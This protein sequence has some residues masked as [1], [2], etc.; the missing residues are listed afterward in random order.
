MAYEGFS[1][2]RDPVH[3]VRGRRSGFSTTLLEITDFRLWKVALSVK[4]RHRPRQFDLHNFV[5][6]RFHRD[7]ENRAQL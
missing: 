3:H 1:L 2:H 7:P 4:Q 6:A 5:S